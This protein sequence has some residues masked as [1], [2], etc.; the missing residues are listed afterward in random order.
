MPISVTTGSRCAARRRSRSRQDAGSSQHSP[1]AR[2]VAA[3]L[4]YWIKCSGTAE[5]PFDSDD[6]RPRKR[7]WQR[8]HG[9]V[10]AFPRRPRIQGGDRLV[11]YAVGSARRFGAGRIYLVEEV[12]SE[13]PE[14]GGHERWPWVVEVCELASVPRLAF[15]PEL[16]E[17]GVSPRSLSQHSHIGLPV[18]AGRL[19]ERL[20]A[21]AAEEARSFVRR[22]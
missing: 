7:A 5:H 14:P 13:E 22:R 10:S 16:S 18:E 8:E 15:A 2:V 17:I 11:N 12:V 21:Q 19:A 20:I 1:R 6:W 4:R 9:P 3:R